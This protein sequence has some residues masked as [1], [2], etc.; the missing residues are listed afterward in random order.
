MKSQKAYKQNHVELDQQLQSM[1]GAHRRKGMRLWTRQN[2]GPSELHVTHSV[3]HE[4]ER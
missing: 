4:K 1:A 2:V 3:Q